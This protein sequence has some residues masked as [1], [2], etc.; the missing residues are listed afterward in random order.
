MKFIVPYVSLVAGV[1][2]SESDA[3]DSKA[4]ARLV[5]VVDNDTM[6]VLR[7]SL[8]I[9]MPCICYCIG[10]TQGPT[11]QDETCHDGQEAKT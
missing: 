1:A 3:F 4:S 11:F 5:S 9:Q 8:L 6:H 7:T 10:P 2:A